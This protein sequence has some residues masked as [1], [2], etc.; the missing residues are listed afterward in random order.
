MFDID[1]FLTTS[2]VSVNA[3]AIRFQDAR[4]G[5]TFNRTIF[6][7]GNAVSFKRLAEEMQHYG[8]ILLWVDDQPGDVPGKLNWSDIFGQFIQQEPEHD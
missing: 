1:K 6:R 8:Y 5:E 4:T 3:T 7:P 2:T